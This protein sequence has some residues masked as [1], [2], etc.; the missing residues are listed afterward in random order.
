[1]EASAA[2]ASGPIDKAGL[3]RE[4]RALH[5]RCTAFWWGFSTSEFFAPLGEAWSPADNVRHLIKSSRPVARALALPK[6]L[7]ALRFGISWHASRP[8]VEIRRIYCEA[9]AG[10]VTAGRYAPELEI[11][12]DDWEGARREL[13][14][15]WDRVEA[16]LEGAV[17]GWGER[18]L[19]ALRL[20]HPALGLLT[21]REMLCFTL[22]H[23]L[24]HAENVA[25]RSGRSLPD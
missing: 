14:E 13:M 7:L 23:N 18:S 20:P 10:G 19:D 9:L 21:V 15:R 25:R 2:Q 3:L 4:L 11:V 1:L 5:V 17:A 16:E 6:V 8:Y 24:H 12:K 22:Y